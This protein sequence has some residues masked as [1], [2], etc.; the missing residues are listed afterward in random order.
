[1]VQ[2]TEKISNAGS[3]AKPRGRP[4]AYDPEAALTRAME[5]FWKSGYAGTS[6]DDLAAA[7]GMNRPSLYAAFGDKRALYLKALRHYWRMGAREMREVLIEDRPLRDALNEFYRRAIGI[8]RGAPG[9][10]PGCVSVST[11]PSAAAEDDEIRIALA[12]SVRRLD[13]RLETLVRH[14]QQ[15]GEIAPSA[16]AA[17]LA[18]LSA[19]TLHTIAIRARAG[20]TAEEL[21]QMASK[22]VS[23]ICSVGKGDDCG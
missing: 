11:A 20:V 9:R 17:A 3:R 19:A 16:D 22:A 23:A 21:E 7:T 6:L 18:L 1:M 15:R 13:E 4:R 12:E 14:A 8:Y 5:T 10:P 2:N